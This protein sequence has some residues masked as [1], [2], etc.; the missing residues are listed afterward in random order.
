M[1]ELRYT[2]VTDGSSDAA[3]IPILTWLLRENGVEYAIQ[4]EWADLGRISRRKRRRLDNKIYWSIELYPCDL[5]LFTGTLKESHVKTVSTEITTA[6]QR[7]VTPVPPT[8]CVVPVR[9]QEAWLLFDETA[10]NQAAGNSS[11]RQSLNLP[12][13]NRLENLSDPKVQLY[14]RLKQA[15]NLRGR[16]LRNFP[17]SQYA[18]RVTQFIQDFS[19]LRR[20]S[21]FAALESELQQIIKQQG[22][23]A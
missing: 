5:Y 6:I 18:R 22:W 21:A 2:L 15:S 1:T 16:R 14:N 23:D 3:L 10:I 9:M 11:N 13:I 12:S 20:L 7:I 8:I 17:V 4:S 19:P